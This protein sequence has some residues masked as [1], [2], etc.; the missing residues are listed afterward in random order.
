MRTT[1]NDKCFRTYV[2]DKWENHG[3]DDS[4]DSFG[5]IMIE[6]GVTTSVDDTATTV[7]INSIKK[8]LRNMEEKHLGKMCVFF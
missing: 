3:G 6:S 5:Y 7:E 2:D 8:C 1:I 4:F